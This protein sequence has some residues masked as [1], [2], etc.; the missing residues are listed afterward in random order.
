MK[1]EELK[2]ELFILFVVLLFLGVILLSCIGIIFLPYVFEH[3]LNW[4]NY[5]SL[6]LGVT[7][8]IIAY[9]GIKI[10]IE[11]SRIS[12][13]SKEMMESLAKSTFLEVKGIFED[14]RLSLQ[15]HRLKIQDIV[16]DDNEKSEVLII[17]LSEYK[18]DFYYNIWKC[19]TY[20]EQAEVLLKWAPKKFQNKVINLLKNYY[21]ELIIGK[22]HFKFPIDDEYKKHIRWMYEKVSI[23]PAFKDNTKRARDIEELM[24]KLNPER[25]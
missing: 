14:V 10:S 13:V 2:E 20:L 5:L 12:N 19:Y 9:I 17:L 16:E 18:T 25:V 8:V 22:R 3:F 4:T 6:F 21:N 15:K 23:Y 1:C 24:L 7:S 11:S